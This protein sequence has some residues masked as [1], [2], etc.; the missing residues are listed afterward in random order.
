MILIL[1]QGEWDGAHTD[2]LDM[3]D[4]VTSAIWDADLV[5]IPDGVHFRIMKNRLS[6]T[7]G[8]VTSSEFM[9]L[10]RLHSIRVK[11]K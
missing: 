1:S 11:T 5:A 3:R 8:H 7:R 4:P 2:R 10:L 6:Q 9:E